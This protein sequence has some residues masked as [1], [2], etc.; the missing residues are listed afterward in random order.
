[1][2]DNISEKEILPVGDEDRLIPTKVHEKDI[3]IAFLNDQRDQLSRQISKAE[4]ERRELLKRAKECNITTDA[5]YKIV[6]VPIY[7]NKHVDVEAL[8]RLAPDKYNLIVQNLTSI[9]MDKLKEQ[10]Q[11]IQVKIAQ[12]DVKAVLKDKVLLAQII[13]EVKEPSGYEVSVVKR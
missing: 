12:S 13:P 1:M 6:E 9:A 7:P 3:H 4:V 11:K 5:E 8:K 10:M 2:L